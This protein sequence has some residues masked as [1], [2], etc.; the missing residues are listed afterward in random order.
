MCYSWHMS[1]EISSFF[2]KSAIALLILIEL[3]QL[4]ENGNFC[5]LSG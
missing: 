4:L 1:G 2:F 3:H 5:R